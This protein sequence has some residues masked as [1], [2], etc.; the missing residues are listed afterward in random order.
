MT[1]IDISQIRA[2]APR[3]IDQYNKAFSGANVATIACTENLK[4]DY[5]G[6]DVRQGW[7]VNE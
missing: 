1:T 7:R 2:L 3:P 4:S 6:D 5:S